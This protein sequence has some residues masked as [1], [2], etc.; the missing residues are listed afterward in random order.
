MERDVERDVDRTTKGKRIWNG[1]VLQLVNNGAGE[2]ENRSSSKKTE[3]RKAYQ[4]Y[5]K[6]SKCPRVLIL[7]AST[8]YL[9][10]FFLQFFFPRPQGSENKKHVIL[11][12]ISVRENCFPLETSGYKV[13]SEAP[14]LFCFSAE[15]LV[16]ASVA[17]VS[18]KKEK[19][20]EW[21]TNEQIS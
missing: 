19:K 20:R 13:P 5:G 10:G 18:Y 12:I 17:A 16:F 21:E 4:K 11:V 3:G 7:S 9:Y 15:V 6:Y 8:Q 14:L 1:P 2:I